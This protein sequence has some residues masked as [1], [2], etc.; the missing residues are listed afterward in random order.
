MRLVEK[1]MVNV[2]SWGEYEFKGITKLDEM[3]VLHLEQNNE[4]LDIIVNINTDI[5]FQTIESDAFEPVWI[6]QKV[7][8]VKGLKELD[9]DLMCFINY[10]LGKYGIGFSFTF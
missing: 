2:L 3:A 8:N 5:V 10:N 7:T 9:F 1:E 4:Q 6:E